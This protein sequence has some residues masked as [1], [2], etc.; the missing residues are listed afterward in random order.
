MTDV[1]TEEELK[2][3]LIRYPEWHRES[4][5]GAA[6]VRRIG[7]SIILSMLSGLPGAL[8]ISQ[9]NIITT[10]NNG[11]LGELA[12]A[13]WS[14]DAGGVTQADWKWS[15]FVTICLPELRHPPNNLLPMKTG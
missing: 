3:H 8:L 15:R 5:G 2:S 4:V 14:H 11:F 9:R 6:C 13:W 10:P 1:L 12:V 7:P